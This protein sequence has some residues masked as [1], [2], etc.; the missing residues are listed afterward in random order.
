MY[1]FHKIYYT[2]IHI[3]VQN[4]GTSGTIRNIKYMQINTNI[5]LKL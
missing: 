2:G 5:K 3:H 1:L 4:P